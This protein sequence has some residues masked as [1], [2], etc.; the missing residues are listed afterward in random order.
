MS[1][2]YCDSLFRRVRSCD[3]LAS[4]SHGLE[5]IFDRY[6]PTELELGRGD[7]FWR[8]RSCDGEPWPS[9][10]DMGAPPS[11]VAGHGRFNDPGGSLL[12]TSI[13][14]ETALSEIG[15]IVNQVVQVIGYR[16]VLGE[17]LRLAV[18]GDLMHVHKL[19]YMRF[20]GSDPD[21]SVSRY[22]N[23]LGPSRGR[24]LIYLDAFLHSLLADT[25]ASRNGYVFTRAV[26]AMIFRNPAID[27]IA[28]QSAKDPLGYNV[29]VRPEAAASKLHATSCFQ[30]QVTSIREFCFTDFRTLR[31]AVH[32]RDGELFEWDEPLPDGARRFFNLTK[33]EYD[34]AM[35]LRG[36]PN[37]FLAVKGAHRNR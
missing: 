11:G 2:D 32:L 34:T 25:E 19:G 29:V 28:F 18:V 15:V 7:V 21:L 27:G 26:A 13:R 22:L 6:R 3:S 10:S 23:S 36:D 5:P 20:A 17:F 12:Y 16:T 9:I 30:C 33:Q 4:I 35:A 1:L 37:A 31:D 8:A 24:E 14:E